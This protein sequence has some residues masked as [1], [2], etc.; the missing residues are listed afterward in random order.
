MLETMKRKVKLLRLQWEKVKANKID[1]L[2]KSYENSY[3]TYDTLKLYFYNL[4]KT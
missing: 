2:I 1:K 4:I 3:I